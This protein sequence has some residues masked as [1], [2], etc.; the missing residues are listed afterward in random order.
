MLIRVVDRVVRSAMIPGIPPNDNDNG[1]GATAGTP[2][3]PPKSNQ[4]RLVE[5]EVFLYLHT[6]GLRP[7]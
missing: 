4:K 6:S 1:F 5:V 3:T 2:A 7:E